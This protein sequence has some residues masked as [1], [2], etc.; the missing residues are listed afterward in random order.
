MVEES[1][2]ALAREPVGGKGRKGGSKRGFLTGSKIV[3]GMP[4][5][6][7]ALNDTHT[8][9]SRMLLRVQ[10]FPAATNTFC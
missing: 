10:L 7:Q 5:T 1:Q 6:P 2:A 4:C 3:V 8:L 9:L